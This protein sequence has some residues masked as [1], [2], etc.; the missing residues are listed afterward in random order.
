MSTQKMNNDTNDTTLNHSGKFLS[1]GMKKISNG[2]DHISYARHIIK[3]QSQEMRAF[4]AGLNTQQGP[5]VP[6]SLTAMELEAFG[7]SGPLRVIPKYLLKALCVPDMTEPTEAME[8]TCVKAVASIL[9]SFWLKFH[10]ILVMKACSSEDNLEP[11]GPTGFDSMGLKLK[12][13][14][15]P[16]PNLIAPEPIVLSSGFLC[17]GVFGD[18]VKLLDDPLNVGFHSS[19]EFEDAFVIS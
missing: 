3:R 18:E 14:E 16:G 8:F 17:C 11:E 10:D 4:P 19:P 2:V 13:S 6:L 12:F 7:I 1:S 15:P 5:A 9:A